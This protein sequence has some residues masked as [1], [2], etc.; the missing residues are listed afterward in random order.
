MAR[1][2]DVAAYIVNQRGSMSSPQLHVL[3]YYV[4]AWW[5]A[6][7]DAPVFDACLEASV[8][9]PV[10]SALV[11]EQATIGDAAALSESV[12]AACDHVLAVYGALPAKY[13]AGLAQFEGPWRDAREA[14]ERDGDEHP[15]ITTAAM[16]RFYRG[17]T[18]EQGSSEY[19][20]A[21]AKTLMD[22]HAECLARLAR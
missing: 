5:L 10:V 2:Q 3:L 22:E 13:L 16:M 18:P 11:D 19:Q 17:R 6:R 9:G 4:Q 20:L 7:H 21:I 14:G 15:V 8:T 12:R 1:V